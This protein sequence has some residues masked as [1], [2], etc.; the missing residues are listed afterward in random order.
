MF[1]AG[2]EV[3][4]QNFVAVVRLRRGCGRAT[5]TNKQIVK[6]NKTKQKTKNKNKHLL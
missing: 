3:G 2:Q 1:G 4:A 5:Q 6:Q